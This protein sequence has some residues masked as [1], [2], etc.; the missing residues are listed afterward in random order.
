MEL[1]MISSASQKFWHLY[2]LDAQASREQDEM[3][4][5]EECGRA[6]R[7]AEIGGL[8]RRRCRARSTP[9]RWS[10][11]S[12]AAAW[13]PCRGRPG[14]KSGLG[15]ARGRSYGRRHGDGTGSWRPGVGGE[16]LPWP[17]PRRWG[18]WSAA[19]RR[20]IAPRPRSPARVWM[21]SRVCWFIRFAR[22]LGEVRWIA[23]SSDHVRA[24]SGSPLLPAN[25]RSG[26]RPDSSIDAH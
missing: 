23:G 9:T 18:C 4:R 10:R 3:L 17:C 19:R 22:V 11:S 6:R 13:A 15:V 5:F 1:T 16:G 26:T 2:G 25:E 14:V 20:A 24:A 12:A 8:P 21:E 7:G